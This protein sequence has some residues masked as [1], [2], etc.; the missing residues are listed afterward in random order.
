MNVKVVFFF[1][2]VK[3]ADRYASAA[4]GWTETFYGFDNS[5]GNLDDWLQSDDAVTYIQLRRACLPPGY[6]IAWLRISDEANPRSFKL[7]AIQAGWGTAKVANTT[8]GEP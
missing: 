6:R 4:L 7:S 3:A 5:L 1:E 2:Y 8:G